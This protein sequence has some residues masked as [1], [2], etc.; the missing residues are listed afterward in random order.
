MR[1]KTSDIQTE[2]SEV[3]KTSPSV[4]GRACHRTKTESEVALGRYEEPSDNISFDTK[5]GKGLYAYIWVWIWF[6]DA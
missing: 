5:N 6:G 3:H 1:T 2:G 4:S